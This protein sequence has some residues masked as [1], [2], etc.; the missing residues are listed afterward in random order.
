[1]ACCADFFVYQMLAVA[2]VV[3]TL[4]SNTDLQKTIRNGK[5]TKMIG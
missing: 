4:T 2:E 3:L 5:S 1:M